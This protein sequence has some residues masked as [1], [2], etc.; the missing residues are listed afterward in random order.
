MKDEGREGERERKRKKEM[1]MPSNIDMFLMAYRCSRLG[2]IPEV[3]K[4]GINPGQGN[5]VLELHL[6][7]SSKTITLSIHNELWIPNG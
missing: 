5:L 3:G 1:F 6:K 4:E 7:V 2:G